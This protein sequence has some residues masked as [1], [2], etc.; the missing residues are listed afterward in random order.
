MGRADGG[1]GMAVEGVG[2]GGVEG[3]VVYSPDAAPA[4]ASPAS[5]HV[6]IK[7]ACDSIFLYSAAFSSRLPARVY[8]LRTMPPWFPASWS[9]SSADTAYDHA[10]HSWWS[11]HTAYHHAC[12]SWWSSNS[13]HCYAWP[14]YAGDVT[15]EAT[16]GSGSSSTASYSYPWSNYTPTD[17]TPIDV[18]IAIVG[19]PYSKG[20]RKNNV[21]ASYRSFSR[22]ILRQLLKDVV[23]RIRDDSLHE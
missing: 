13:W 9:P 19:I 18:P 1:E 14:W 17:G 16:Y 21:P 12:H 8:L 11:S 6:S 7:Y 23:G 10:C 20:N 5:Y 4:S 3:I 15:Q 2:G 22:G